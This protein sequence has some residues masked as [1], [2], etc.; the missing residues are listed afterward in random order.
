M[1]LIKVLSE[2]V[3]KEIVDK[4]QIR[5]IDK[6]AS[7]MYGKNYTWKTISQKL[8]VLSFLV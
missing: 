8:E 7:E 4:K 1:A 5:D 2:L 3:E 6:Y